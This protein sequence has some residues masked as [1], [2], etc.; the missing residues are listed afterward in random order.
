MSID[1]LRTYMQNDIY[2][3]HANPNECVYAWTWMVNFA[4]E[5]DRSIDRSS[6]A[7]LLR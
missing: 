5:L 1:V 2:I 7:P 6:G 4:W 3:G